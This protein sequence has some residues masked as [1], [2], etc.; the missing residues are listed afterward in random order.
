M[1]AILTGDA[2][3]EVICDDLR[4]ILTRHATGL[5][6]DY[7]DKDDSETALRSI[8]TQTRHKEAIQ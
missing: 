5:Q 4:V 7:Y 1:K 3:F 2:E 6:I 8:F